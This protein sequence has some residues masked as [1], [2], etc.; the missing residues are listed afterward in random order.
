MLKWRKRRHNMRTL[1]QALREINYIVRV[2]FSTTINVIW[3][4]WSG[5]WAD[6]DYWKGDRSI[7]I[8]K[9]HHPRDI[10]CPA[11]SSSIVASHILSENFKVIQ[12]YYFREYKVWVLLKKGSMSV[13]DVVFEPT[14][15]ISFKY[16]HLD[17]LRSVDMILTDFILS[18]WT[19]TSRQRFCL[20]Y[21][22]QPIPHAVSGTTESQIYHRSD[23]RLYLVLVQMCTSLPGQFQIPSNAFHAWL[24]RLRKPLFEG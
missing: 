3:V 7:A 13:E 14:Y 18:R 5:V 6:R 1:T 17:R 22:P 16:V 4:R 21:L 12:M 9:W 11:F 8:W 20:T 23:T 24:E 2:R 19:S 10:P 15:H